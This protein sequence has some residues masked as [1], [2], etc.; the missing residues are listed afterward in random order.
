[1]DGKIRRRLITLNRDFY[2]QFARTFAESRAQPQPGF[3]RL[4]EYVVQDNPR[5]LDVGCGEGRF[6]R[7]L[8]ANVAEAQ[9]TGV[10][11]TDILLEYA[12]AG[13]VAVSNQRG[14][15]LIR[16]LA[17]PDCLDGLGKFEVI[18][19]LATLQH[20]PDEIQRGRLLTEMAAH[21]ENSGRILMSN[22]QFLTSDRQRRKILDWSEVGLEGED[23]EDND[24]LLSW[25]R[26]GL[27]FRYVAYIDEEAIE[28]LALAAGLKIINQFRSDGREGN[29]NLY[30]I[31][32]F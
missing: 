5:L 18:V 22:W 29:L 1:M 32:G 6:G 19:C 31:M 2:T 30:T 12:Q 17:E 28:G 14:T 13:L 9:Y 8:L 21:L 27:G 4:L 20:I 7:F 15:F 25:Q 3:Q 16:D 26:D 24:F 23:L 10:D 11:F